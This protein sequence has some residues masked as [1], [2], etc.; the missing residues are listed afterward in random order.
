MHHHHHCWCIIIITHKSDGGKEDDDG[1][2]VVEPEHMVVDADGVPLVEQP[3]DPS[4]DEG[5]HAAKKSSSI[6]SL[7][8]V[9]KYVHKILLYPAFHF[10]FWLIQT[11]T[12]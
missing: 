7:K 4:K 12:K 8:E 1:G 3:G 10:H 6:E 9:M 2:P 5:K 11:F